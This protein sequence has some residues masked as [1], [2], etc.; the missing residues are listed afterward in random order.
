MHP[1]RPPPFPVS[2]L[3]LGRE[4]GQRWGDMPIRRW[5][6]LLFFPP[7]QMLNAHHT[8]H[9]LHRSPLYIACSRREYCTVITT[10]FA[11]SEAKQQW[12]P[13]APSQGCIQTKS[14][15]AVKSQVLLYNLM[16]VVWSGCSSA[17]LRGF[18]NNMQCRC[19][20]KLKQGQ[21]MQEHNLTSHCDG[22]STDQSEQ[23]WAT[24]TVTI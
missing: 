24:L 3:S 7:S 2:A 15:V 18:C 21:L 23:S 22:W 12:P 11:G 17:D 9:R 8:S 5:P 19:S 16:W 4:G 13:A 1:H 14:G 10:S 20:G 6:L